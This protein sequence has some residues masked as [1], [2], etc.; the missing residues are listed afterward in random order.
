M[1]SGNRVFSGPRARVK[2]D[3]KPQGWGRGVRIRER[4]AFDPLRVLNNVRVKEQVPL[5]YDVELGMDI[6]QLVDSSLKAQGIF[7]Q[8]GSNPDEHLSNIL[9][10]KAMAILVEDAKTDTIMAN[11]PDAKCAEH[12]MDVSAGAVVGT[13]LQFVATVMFDQSEQS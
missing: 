7:P 4:Q 1:P 2:I 3:G 10:Q 13:D 12:G 11:F 8:V 6:F 5:N 9:A